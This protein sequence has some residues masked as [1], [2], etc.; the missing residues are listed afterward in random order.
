MTGSCEYG[1][2]KKLHYYDH[3]KGR[4]LL[5]QCPYEALQGKNYCKFHDDD[6]VHANPRSI[7]ESFYE[8]VKDAEQANK[9]LIC[10]GFT[11]PEK[12]EF[13]SKF[14]VDVYL[15][16]ATFEQTADFSGAEFHERI[17][18]AETTFSGSANFN[19]TRFL[20]EADFTDAFFSEEAVFKSTKF[21]SDAFFDSVFLTGM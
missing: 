6:Y 19:G 8:L 2:E 7:T 9:P 13:G 1:S 16:H 18:C 5:F 17:I 21:G 3:D 12:V 14:R 4:R 20:K 15:T 10:M 11:F